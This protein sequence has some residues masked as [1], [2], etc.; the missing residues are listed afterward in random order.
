M[1]TGKEETHMRSASRS[2][3]RKAVLAAF[4]AGIGWLLAP[5]ASSSPQV[6]QDKRVE[7]ALK[8][9]RQI[10]SELTDKVRGL[11]LTELEKGGYDGAVGVCSEVAQN[12]T[13]EFNRGTGRSVRRVSLGYRNTKDI[14][15]AYESRA[16]KRFD[17]QNREKRLASE[18]YEV[19][20]EQGRDYLRYLKPIVAGKMCLNCHGR[21]E[22]FPS[23]VTAV[24]KEKYPDDR[25]TGYR[26]GDLR[27]AVSVK[28]ALP[29]RADR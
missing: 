27:G 19:I 11:L 14:P 24:L 22:Q 17:R 10:S 15:D 18:Y 20:R 1:L 25:A 4:I 29:A 7:P 3:I 16:L 2:T 5:A 23:H 12:I 6:K 26:E 8:Q 9:A 21:S 28:I 13:Q